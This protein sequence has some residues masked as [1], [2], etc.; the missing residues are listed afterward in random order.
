MGMAW[1]RLD[2]QITELWP[3]C[4]SDTG[5]QVLVRYRPVVLWLL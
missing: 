5:Q 1:V 3:R 4:Q 2:I